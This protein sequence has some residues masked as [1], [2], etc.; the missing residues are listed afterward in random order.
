MTTMKPPPPD[1]SNDNADGV[2]ESPSSSESEVAESPAPRVGVGSLLRFRLSTFLAVT[3]LACIGAAWWF[4]SAP[5]YRIYDDGSVAYSQMQPNS[6][7]GESLSGDY[8]LIDARGRVMLRGAHL[9]GKPNGR[10]TT[11]YS[12]GFRKATGEVRNGVA[13]GVW[14]FWAPGGG[15]LAELTFA[16]AADVLRGVDPGTI[17]RHRQ[18]AAAYWHASTGKPAARGQFASDLRHGPW[19]FWN[20]AGQ[21]IA[22]GTFDRGMRHGE[23]RVMDEETGAWRD[24]YFLHGVEYGDPAS[25]G[26]RLTRLGER[27]RRAESSWRHD[28]AELAKHRELALPALA[29]GLQSDQPAIQARS[30]LVIAHLLGGSPARPQLP[31]TAVKRVRQL[32]VSDSRRVRQRAAM[33]LLAIDRDD[34]LPHWRTLANT[35]SGAIREADVPLDLLG[36]LAELDQTIRYL[37]PR[38]P[39]IE[40]RVRRLLAR[41]AGDWVVNDAEHFGA[42]HPRLRQAADELSKDPDQIVAILFQTSH[43]W[44]AVW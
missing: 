34:Q 22:Q 5:V 1:D 4:R 23:W 39:P 27:L 8:H 28:L 37:E 43:Q 7:G 12:N 25:V 33:V 26:K 21:L 40:P 9:E 44:Q 35:M 30:L 13:I 10:F 6:E 29:D 32:Y 42:V 17:P 2:S 38:E 19:K 3:A 36:A 31:E 15:K 24:V 14:Q 20:E 16:R 41:V 11:Y 18:G